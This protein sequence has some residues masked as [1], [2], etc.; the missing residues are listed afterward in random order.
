MWQVRTILLTQLDPTGLGEE[1]GRRKRENR[2]MEDFR[3]LSR[4][5]GDRSF[6]SLRDKRQS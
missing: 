5:S 3:V 1:E 6:K 2:E 4:F